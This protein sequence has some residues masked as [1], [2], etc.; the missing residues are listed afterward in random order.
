MPALDLC[1]QKYPSY[2]YCFSSFIIHRFFSKFINGLSLVDLFQTGW[3]AAN[4]NRDWLRMGITV[5]PRSLDPW[6]MVMAISF[7]LSNYQD[8]YIDEY[9]VR[10]PGITTFKETYEKTVIV[11]I[12]I[13]IVRQ[14]FYKAWYLNLVLTRSWFLLLNVSHKT[15]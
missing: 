5:C 6:T 1:Q 14:S 11:I 8:V 9:R 13:I 10:L 7:F 3:R 12:T 2:I 15:V 4:S